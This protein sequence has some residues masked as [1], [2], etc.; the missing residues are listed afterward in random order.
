VRH[1]GKNE[2]K[3]MGLVKDIQDY[4]SSK[5]GSMRAELCR[6]FLD[7]KQ[8]LGEITCG[9][10]TVYSLELPWKNNERRVS[11]IPDGL[12]KCTRENHKKFGWC[13]RLHNVPNRDGVLIHSGTTFE[14][15]LGCILPALNQKDINGDGLP[16]N[17]SSKA[18]LAK[19]TALNFTEINIWT[20][21]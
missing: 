1:F 21:P 20:R 16:D 11:C 10:V 17:V 14:H 4:Q 19:L 15:T 6:V 5:D 8:T 3:Q 2:V 13:Y 18:A 7:E 9:D 12:Y